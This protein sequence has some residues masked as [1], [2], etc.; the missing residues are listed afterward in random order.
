MNFSILVF[1]RKLKTFTTSI[2]AS[3][4]SSILTSAIASAHKTFVCSLYIFAKNA[5]VNEVKE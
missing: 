2:L 5:F 4:I 3:T 1:V